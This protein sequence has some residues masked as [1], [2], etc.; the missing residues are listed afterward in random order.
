MQSYT[1]I[2]CRANFLLKA[3]IKN[4][5]VAAIPVV[6]IEQTIQLSLFFL[7]FREK[8][9]CSLWFSPTQKQMLLRQMMMVLRTI[10]Y[11]LGRVH[12][13]WTCEKESFCK[14]R[15]QEELGRYMFQKC[16]CKNVN[17]Y[18][19]ETVTEGDLKRPKSCQRSLWTTPYELFV[20]IVLH[21][22]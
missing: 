3:R 22:N 9:S 18:K 2:G 12:G 20:T 7:Y 8:R 15:L 14:L 10:K 5:P 1:D 6:R 19:V 16:N 17:F 13:P 21:R 4:S 11:Y